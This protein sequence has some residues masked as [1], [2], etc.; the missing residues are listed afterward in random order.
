[1]QNN[2]YLKKDHHGNFSL[3]YAMPGLFGRQKLTFNNGSLEFLQEEAKKNIVTLQKILNNETK[4]FFPLRP[5]DAEKI[6]KEIE[7]LIAA[8]EYLKKKKN[9]VQLVKN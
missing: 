9:I 2:F 4:Y 5:G 6:Q 3:T 8:I 7:T 1:M